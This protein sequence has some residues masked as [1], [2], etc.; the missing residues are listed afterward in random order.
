MRGKFDRYLDQVS[1][2]EF[3]RHYR[4][5]TV[6]FPVSEHDEAAVSPSCRDPGDDKFLALALHCSAQTLI[7]SD[8]DLL[9]L[10]PW[11][12]IAI[13]KPAQFLS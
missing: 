3:V 11:H 12:G 13:Q 7:A 1:R 6:L 4:A 9:V 5:T 8:E 10:N 2:W